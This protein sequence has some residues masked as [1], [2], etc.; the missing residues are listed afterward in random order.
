M[1]HPAVIILSCTVA[2]TALGISILFSATAHFPNSSPHFFI[3]RQLMWLG[4]AVL[5]GGVVS[6]INLEKVRALAWPVM[7]LCLIGLILTLIPGVG[8]EVNGA[9]RWLPM[10]IGRLQISEFTKLGLVFCLA[11]YLG[12][13]QRKMDTFWIGFFWP[14]V[15]IAIPVG[16]IFLQPD[17]GTAALTAAVGGTLLFLAGARLRYLV[18]VAISGLGLFAVAVYFNPVRFGRILSFMDVEAH[19]MD[20]AYQL[21]QAIL[22]FGTGGVSGVGLGNG[23]QQLAFLPEAH[24][25]F[26]LA[27]L[28][29]ELGF[30]FTGA[31]LALFVLLFLAGVFHLRKAPN[32]YQFLLIT[33]ALLVLS[34]Q[35]IINMGVVTGTLPTK[36][37]SLPFISYG[38]SN[39]VVVFII[40]G[41]LINTSIAW[42]R[43]IETPANR[44]DNK[45]VRG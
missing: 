26:I 8:V 30:F 3:S 36:G 7:G 34:V 4:V 22:A 17:Y 19:R 13:N 18:P 43:Q 25:D 15:F 35:A 40:V 24:T 12:S 27:V 37:I 14:S 44:R 20:G 5:A 11:A 6:V 16:L 28:A 9:R 29:E 45:E 31:V 10:G 39:L 23:R 42:S 32:L 38:G 2:L 41:L 1:F 33:G 21:W